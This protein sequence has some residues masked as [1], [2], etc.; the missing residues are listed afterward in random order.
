LFITSIV[1]A[2]SGSTNQDIPVSL[3]HMDAQVFNDYVTALI[4]NKEPEMKAA[5]VN[6]GSIS[7]FKLQAAKFEV[8]TGKLTIN[9]WLY[10]KNT[11]IQGALNFEIRVSADPSPQVGGCCLGIEGGLHSSKFFTDLLLALVKNMINQR[12]AGQQFWSDNKPHPEYKVFKNDNLTYIV[13]RAFINNQAGNKQFKQFSAAT[14]V[15]NLE[16][17]FKNIKCAGFDIGTGRA[18]VSFDIGASL[19]SVLGL[20]LNFDNAGTAVADFDFYIDGDNRS[21][22]VKLSGFKLTINGISPEINAMAQD[23]VN[24]ELNARKILIPIDMPKMDQD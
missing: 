2:E 16:V 4:K 24:N 10:Y 6:E 1:Y 18:Q 20:A 12:L 7:D 22:W 11:D 13:N 15:G 23:L 14:D 19:K 17:E 3:Q 8:M 5:L 9:F 21:W